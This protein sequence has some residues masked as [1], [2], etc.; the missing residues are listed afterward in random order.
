[1]PYLSSAKGKRTQVQHI[2]GSLELDPHRNDLR[3]YRIVKSTDPAQC[4]FHLLAGWIAGQVVV[5][6]GKALADIQ[7]GLE[8]DCF[9][10][11]TVNLVNSNSIIK[12]DQLPFR[13]L[14]SEPAVIVA[15][16]G[17]TGT[18]KGIVL[19]RRSVEW[20]TSVLINQFS[21][22]P[23]DIFGNLSPFHGLGGLRGTMM[24][25]RHGVSTQF[26]ENL[27][28]TAIGYAETVLESG[29]TT[30]LSGSSFVR[31]L[32]ATGRW[33]SKKN[34]KLTSIMS[35]GSLY[36][37]VASVAVKNTYDVSRYPGSLSLRR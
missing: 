18:P 14:D 1:M 15:S 17:T 28:A 3:R 20:T 35:C 13:S 32:D 2:L 33:L 22:N 9:N 16:S 30:V 34:T 19:S 21:M 27:E 31:L 23:G 10:A 37:D 36:D 6:V 12:Y 11:A 26:F 7:P 8:P 24:A 25:L 29:V 4:A 5:M